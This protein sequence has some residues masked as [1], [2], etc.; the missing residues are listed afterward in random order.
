MVKQSITVLSYYMRC[1][2][3]Q[4]NSKK[5]L[6]E[7]LGYRQMVRHM[8][9]THTRGGSNPPSPALGSYSKILFKAEI[10]KRLRHFPCKKT[11]LVRIQLLA[12]KEPRI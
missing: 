2:W 8:T 12:Q 10:V 6:S 7:F 9:L 3:Q 4:V 5:Q 1:F 11:M